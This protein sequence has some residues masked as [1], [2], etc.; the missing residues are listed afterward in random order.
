VLSV[1]QEPYEAP[2]GTASPLTGRESPELHCSEEIV[3]LEIGMVLNDFFDHH[4]GG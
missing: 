4:A 1:H 2:G 3:R